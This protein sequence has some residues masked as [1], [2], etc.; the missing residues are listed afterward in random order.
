M[1]DVADDGALPGGWGPTLADLERRRAAARAMGGEERLTRRQAT[2]RLDARTR[3]DRLLD[4][5]SFRELGTLVGDEPADAIVAGTGSIDG[6]PVMIGAEDFTVAGGTIG[7]GTNAKRFRIA[8]LALQERVPLV[9]LLEGAGYRTTERSMSRG[10]TDVLMQARCSG[11]VPVVSAV[12]GPSAGHGALVAPL[13]DFTVMTDQAAIFTA[14]PP[15]VEEATGEQVTKEELGG[16]AVAVASGVVHNVAADDGDALDQVRRYLSYFPSSAWSYPSSAD[17][18]DGGPRSTDA[19]LSIVP[20]DGRKPYD[21]GEVIAAV[22]DD[23]DWFEL[24]PGFGP[25]LICALSRI[26]GEAVAIVANQPKVLAGAIDAAAADKGAHLIRVADAFHLP[27]VFLADNPGMLPGPK[28]ERAGVL[29]SGARMFAAQTLAT[30]PKLHVTLRKA[31]GFGSLVMAMVSHDSQTA[32]FA[33][34]GATLGAMGA[35]AS[36]RAVAADATEA[37]RLREAELDAS[38]RTAQGLGFD[39]LIDPRETRNALI[40]ALSRA[41]A[42]RQ[43]AAGPTAVTA[44]WP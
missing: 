1:S 38:Y 11:K 20:R 13:S 9:M 3:V 44:I 27:V 32:T 25:S 30:T 8:E 17:G 18:A 2:G 4:P 16:P 23:G 10:P 22:V 7:A 14:G 31:Y 42:R 21:M 41:C 29:R 28:S 43:A 15:V 39:E 34:P 36:S 26:G 40:G 24:Q 5:G 6:R 37:E 19:L 12:L 33:F 35:G